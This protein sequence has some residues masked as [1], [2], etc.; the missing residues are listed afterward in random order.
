MNSSTYPNPRFLEFHNSRLLRIGHLRRPADRTHHADGSAIRSEGQFPRGRALR[1]R[2]RRDGSAARCPRNEVLPRGNCH[3]VTWRRLVPRGFD[4]WRN[5]NRWP[6]YCR[7]P[8]TRGDDGVRGR[9]IMHLTPPPAREMIEAGV[10]VA[11]ASDFNPNAYCMSMPFVMNVGEKG[12]VKG[13]WD[14]FCL[15]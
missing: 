5:T 12:G 6:F 11:V 8:R 7:Q 13:S 1:P 10:P 3:L 9:W 2:R 4:S 14:A 15:D